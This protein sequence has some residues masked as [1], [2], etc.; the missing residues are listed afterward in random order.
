MSKQVRY[1]GP[2]LEVLVIDSQAGIYAGPI[3]VVKRGENLP[4]NVPDRIRDELAARED[5]TEV[6]SPRVAP[7]Q[8]KGDN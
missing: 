8:K 1:D 5:W 7:E 2:F 4:A 6:P 3:A